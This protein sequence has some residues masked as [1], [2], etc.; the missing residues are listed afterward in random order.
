MDR[1]R[2]GRIFLLYHYELGIFA[3]YGIGGDVYDMRKGN[4]GDEERNCAK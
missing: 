4:T 2:G 3:C 1:L